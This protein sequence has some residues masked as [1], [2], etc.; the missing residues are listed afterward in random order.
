M[1]ETGPRRQASWLLAFLVIGTLV[2]I[3][4]A[5]SIVAAE[6]AGDAGMFVHMQKILG[7]AALGPILA[8]AGAV[9]LTLLLY[10]IRPR[11]LPLLVALAA[12]LALV[13]LFALHLLH[14][15]VDAI[16]DG[17]SLYLL[18]SNGAL[19]AAIFVAAQAA[20]LGSGLHLSSRTRSTAMLAGTAF[21][22]GALVGTSL[23]GGVFVPDPGQSPASE[24]ASL[25]DSA[26]VHGIAV[27][28]GFPCRLL[29]PFLL[30]AQTWRYLSSRSTRWTL[31]AVA[32][33]L[34]LLIVTAI[35]NPQYL[36]LAQRVFFTLYMAWFLLACFA[37]TRT[38]PSA[39]PAP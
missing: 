16:R 18:T 29:F 12:G 25:S 11:S 22:T 8:S 4:A 9:S 39:P 7:D 20:L 5:L 28:L 31:L 3:A 24:V 15:E 26:R 17:F 32:C 37:S 2:S 33:A 30:L 21:L 1:P 36:G 19:A 23:L 35:R 27:G 34:P 14:P 10:R 6:R 38:N 13:L